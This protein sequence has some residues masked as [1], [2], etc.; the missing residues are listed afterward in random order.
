MESSHVWAGKVAKLDLR[1]FVILVG[2]HVNAVLRVLLPF[3]LH[4]R[5]LKIKSENYFDE[6]K[7][8][9]LVNKYQILKHS[10]IVQRRFSIRIATLTTAPVSTSAIL[11]VCFWL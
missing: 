7:D 6:Q 9:G 8:E 4:N 10:S 3:S 5:K 1:G 11:L 2:V